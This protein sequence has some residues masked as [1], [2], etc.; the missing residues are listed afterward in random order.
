MKSIFI[1]VISILM[2]STLSSQTNTLPVKEWSSSSQNPLVLYISGDGGFNNFSTELCTAISKR[3]YSVTAISAKSYF[4]DKKTPEQ[5]AKDITAYLDK[6]FVNRKNQ[7]LIFAGY[8]FGADVA[9]F[10]ITKLPDSVRKKL[11]SVVLLSPSEST[12]F[13]IHWFDIFGGNKKRSM[14]VVTE[15]NKLD[16]IKTVTIFGNDENDFPF[17]SIKLKNYS[18]KILPGGHHFDDN[19]DEVAATMVKYFN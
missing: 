4:W 18:N 13:E 3:G 12:D 8:S 2:A 16:P 17:K 6:Q 15:L 7:Q 14:D 5:T 11:V 10:I 19:T 9:P 1:T